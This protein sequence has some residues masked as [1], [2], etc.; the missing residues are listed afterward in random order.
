MHGF[1]PPSTCLRTSSATKSSVHRP[2]GSSV[3]STVSRSDA[4]A[5]RRETLQTPYAVYDVTAAP[6]LGSGTIV[7]LKPSY[8]GSSTAPDG[9]GPPA[10]AGGPCGSR[11]SAGGAFGAPANATGGGAAASSGASGASGA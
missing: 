10:R 1:S 8:H 7:P 2:I 4:P 5:A 11:A 3:I 9:A 6:E